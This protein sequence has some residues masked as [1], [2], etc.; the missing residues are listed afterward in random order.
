MHVFITV[1]YW[2]WLLLY[3]LLQRDVEKLRFN[4][5]PQ[6]EVGIVQCDMIEP[7]AL[8][9]FCPDGYSIKHINIAEMPMAAEQ[10]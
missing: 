1:V 10:T 8:N 7:F 5:S 6:S 9:A 2:L 3:Q 4:M